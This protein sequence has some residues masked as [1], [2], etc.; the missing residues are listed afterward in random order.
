[1]QVEFLLTHIF[2]L[3]GIATLTVYGMDT[4]C[5][6]CVLNPVDSCTE[7]VE[8]A[9]EKGS[10]AKVMKGTICIHEVCGVFRHAYC[11]IGGR[12]VDQDGKEVRR[13]VDQECN[14]EEYKFDP[15]KKK[16]RVKRGWFRR[17]RRRRSPPP[18]PPNCGQPGTIAHTSLHVTGTSQGGVATYTCQSGYGHTAGSL[19]RTCQSNAQW[20]GSPPTC[21]YMN[22]C[23]SSPC[24]NGGTCKNIPNSYTCSCPSIWKGSR[25]ETDTNE[26]ASTSLNK[27]NQKCNN[28][29]GSFTCSCNTGYRLLPDKHTCTDIDECAEKSSGCDH[30]CANTAGSFTCSCREGFELSSDGKSCQDIDECARG[31]SG[32][33]QNCTNT[34]GSFT[35]SCKTGYKLAINGTSCADIDECTGG[36][37]PCDVYCTNTKGSYHCSCEK[38]Y[39]LNADGKT[40]ED[41]DECATGNGSCDQ[42]CANQPGSFTCECHTGYI[43]SKDGRTCADIDECIKDVDGCSHNCTNTE[44]SF[45]CS[46]LS[47]Y[48]LQPDQKTCTDI[49]DCKGIICQHGGTCRDGLNFFSC[50]C[51][52]GYTSNLCEKDVNECSIHNGGCQDACI[53]T[54]GSYHCGCYDGRQLKP[55]GRSCSEGDRDTV[56]ERF[57]IADGKLP[58]ACFVLPLAH[59]TDGKGLGTKLTS[60]SE[61]YRLIADSE[62]S[63]TLGIAFIKVNDLSLPVSIQGLEVTVSSGKFQLSYGTK[64]N[65]SEGTIIKNDETPDNCKSFELVESDIF[66]FVSAGSFLKTYLLNLFPALPNWIKFEKTSESVLAIQDL[67][68]DLVYG[69]HMEQ[70]TWCEGAP[71]L[72]DHLYSVF[73]LGSTFSLEVMGDKIKVPNPLAGHK[74]CFIIDLCHS[75]GGS[76]FFMVPEE[77]RDL[78]EGITVFKLLKQKNKL[79][80]FPRGIGIS[81]VN[82]INVHHD[83]TELQ[84]WNGDAMVQYPVFPRGDFWIGADVVKNDTK[85]LV[86][87]SADIFIDLPNIEIMLTSIFLDEWGGYVRLTLSASPTLKFKLFGKQYAVTFKNLVT[88]EM[89]LYL[90]V[91]GPHRVWCG[92]KANPPGFFFSLRLEINPFKGV[93][94]LAD[95]GISNTHKAFGFVTYEPP[96]AVLDI[97]IKED[98]LN[99]KDILDRL[100]VRFRIELKKLGIIFRNTTLILADD[101]E[102][103]IETMKSLVSDLFDN[104]LSGDWKE[105]KRILEQ[106]WQEFQKIEHKVK[107]F[108]DDTE[109]IAQNAFKNLTNIIKNEIDVVKINLKNAMEKVTNSLVISSSESGYT[110]FGLKY[111]TNV[112]FFGLKLGEF[113]LEIVESVDHL[114]KCSR[115]EKIKKHFEGEKALRFIGRASRLVVLNIFIKFQAGGGIGGALS[116][117]KNKFSLQLQVY[118]QFLGMKAT[119][120]LFITNS[121]L[122]IYTEGNIWDI[123]LAQLD[124]S[125]EMKSEWHH[126]VYKVQ[127]RFVAK[128]RKRRQIQTRSNSFEDSYL[129]AL[130]KVV[131]TIADMANK[132][133]SQA[134]KGLT[135]AQ[136][137]L[138]KAQNWLKEKQT[139]VRRANG[140]FDSAVA[141]LERAKDK[142]EAA[143]K[144]FED[145]LRKLKAAQRKVDNLCRIRSCKKLCIP[146]VK[147]K[148]C[149]KKVGWVKIPYPCCRFT[150]CMIKVPDPVCLAANLACRVVRGAAYLALEAAKIF[151]RAPMLAFDVAKGAVSVAQIVVDKSRVVLDVAVGLLDMAKIGL[152]YAKGVLEAAKVVLEG[153][154]I[155]IG[156]AAKV[157]ELVI[158]IGLKNLLDVRNCGF[159]VELSTHDLPVFD[160]FCDVNAFRLG[161][162]TITIRIN[163]K[164]IVQS[165]WNAARATI[166]MLSKLIGG[167]GRKRR[168]LE[169]RASAKMHAYLRNIR[170]AGIENGTYKFSNNSYDSIDIVDEIL[171][172]E[173]NTDNDY[174][175]RKIIFKEKC[176]TTAYLMKFMQE[177][178]GSLNEIVNESK[179]YM[180]EM[181][182]L[183]DQLQQFTLDGLAENMTL[184]NAGISRAYAER[185]YNLTEDDLNRALNESQAALM[186]DPLLSEI[187]SSTTLAMESL[188]AEKESIESVNFLEIWL[189]AMSN[190]SSE[191][192]NATECSG[193][194][195][196]VLYA[197]SE[198][199]AAFEAEDFPNIDN[200]RQYIIN[201]EG[202]LIELFQNQSSLIGDSDVAMDNIMSNVTYLEEVNPFCSEAPVF[203]TEL[204]NQTVLNGTDMI[205]TCNVSGSPY[206][207]IQWFT[208]NKIL[209]NETSIELIIANVTVNDSG[210][211]TCLAGNVVANITSR[212]AYLEVVTYDDDECQTNQGGCEQICENFIGSYVCRCFNGYKLNDD[213]KSC[214]DVDECLTGTAN[215]KQACVNTLGSYSCECKDG[216]M[217]DGKKSR[218]KGKDAK[219]KLSGNDT[220]NMLDQT[221]N[222]FVQPVGF[223]GNTSASKEYKYC[224]NVDVIQ[225]ILKL[226][227]SMER[228]FAD[229]EKTFNSKIDKF[230]HHLTRKFTDMLNTAVT[231]LKEELDKKIDDLSKRVQKI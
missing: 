64:Y 145:A 103:N 162:K 220:D 71:V 91:G 51:A 67:K 99:F 89:N 197:I 146:G 95:W 43:L 23:S 45:K 37:A 36:T 195:D 17:R 29:Y 118:A 63:F 5:D 26:C 159:N 44:G 16:V 111:T 183:N 136:G 210:E 58:K 14:D 52:E 121:G 217:L 147:C 124:V 110:G 24:K 211:Y 160:I 68:S 104:I 119:T 2:L 38:G 6:V 130:K 203:Q 3:I 177:A 184:D 182:S 154:K 180:D 138:S 143:K 227:N 219:G 22:S 83:T 231:T 167:I 174:D 207:K 85:L 65:S 35:C 61:W 54:D 155:A 135:A 141:A 57:E 112:K 175:S 96:Q 213:A 30:A 11:T 13:N 90:S 88:S 12:W 150:S 218:S 209:L 216:F 140:K 221:V 185:D 100:K 153:V 49:D 193:F 94:M 194:K 10:N 179:H 115:F 97:N 158:D 32:C 75:N 133:L 132:R 186:N 199:Y 72:E 18:P 80:I 228:K 48:E 93:P 142:L 42:V 196:C 109:F 173:N 126:I 56:F 129:D 117:D 62:T 86:E 187:N 53:N 27:C 230:E 125:A 168:E 144:P 21:S 139:V 137:G 77:S 66:E 15:K 82:G 166:D 170:E 113:D 114:F 19:K 188:N 181:S 41:Q 169:F 39:L 50:T 73:R 84:L 116:S 55:D 101:I 204:R 178:F 202:I 25:C 226:E 164:N 70:T 191:Y 189:N 59:C 156:V 171:G 4:K 229:L 128:S 76:I 92:E 40:C 122:Y 20:S 107:L 215:C 165:L 9:C 161:W 176:K 131:N 34:A 31:T 223:C 149:R 200:V 108:F 134:Q 224:E 87:G 7:N 222:S 206:P 47:G 157:L 120:D 152:E 192:F 212:V 190:T 225:A 78:L 127:G 106:L 98:I 214:S 46:C 208:N 28:T 8:I 81:I 205:F 148:I 172:F 1:M 60:T 123:F 198:L 163:F 201:L 69:R 79:T 102:I 105:K 151:V 74:F 33:E